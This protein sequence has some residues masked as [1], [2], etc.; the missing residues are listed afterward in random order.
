MNKFSKRYFRKKPPP[1][2]KWKR[3]PRNG[4]MVVN[5]QADVEEKIIYINPNISYTY[6]NTIIVNYSEGDSNNIA[7]NS[8]VDVGDLRQGEQ[9]FKTLIH[10][11]GH[12]RYPFNHKF[13]GFMQ[14]EV[15]N[16]TLVEDWACT[17]FLKQRKNILKILLS[18]GYCIRNGRL[19]APKLKEAIYELNT[20]G[21]G[22]FFKIR[23]EKIS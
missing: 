6:R 14:M 15:D 20:N 18:E 7:Y 3:L 1:V 13:L 4:G 2:V 21:S 11:I 10:E 9:Y 16:H 5:G 17:E 22:G 12:F 8:M 23:Y 19:C